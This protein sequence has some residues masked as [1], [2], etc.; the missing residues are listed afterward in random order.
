M[1][2]GAVR[3]WKKA[4]SSRRSQPAMAHFR[5]DASSY[6]SHME[7]FNP[8]AG[9]NPHDVDQ[10][11]AGQF[12]RVGRFDPLSSSVSGGIFGGTPQQQQRGNVA[13]INRVKARANGGG[14]FLDR[15]ALAEANDVQTH[16]AGG[17]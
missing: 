6:G 7:N 17:R 5:T 1:G 4:S 3:F 8:D 14:D 16:A 13:A 11:G 9:L 10:T 15:L 12:K 2:R